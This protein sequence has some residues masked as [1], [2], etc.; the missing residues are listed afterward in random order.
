MR[1][2]FFTSESVAAGHPDKVADQIS[3]GILDAILD[4]DKQARV[5]VESLVTTGLVM[6]AG[7]VTT[8]CYV[9]VPAVARDVV[10]EVGYVDATWGFNYETCA[11]VSSIHGQSP[12]ISQGVSEGEGLHEEQGAGDQGLMFGY[13]CDETPEL[14]PLP[15]RLCHRMMERYAK[16]QGAKALPWARPDG[17][18]QVTVEYRGRKP[19]RVHT[20]VC[21]V[22]HDPDATHDQV[23]KD[24]IQKIIKKVI[25]AKLL[26]SSTIYH[27]NPTGRF[28]MGG[29]MADTGLTGRKIIVDTYG[30]RGRHGGGA[31]SGKDPSKVDRSASY[32]A[33]HCAKNIVAAGLAQE[34]EVQVSYAIGVADPLA[35]YV[36]TFGTG[37]V[38]EQRVEK[39]VKDL[40][41][42]RPKPIIQR[43]DLLR[44]IYKETARFGHFGRE[45][46]QFTWERTDM[47]EALRKAA[48][49]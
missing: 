8:D 38:P 29:P 25:P 20:V 41:D 11:V 26:D 34:C 47:V 2:Y 23:E 39:I 49:L 48:K 6:V 13:A 33:R 24:I 22:Q 44:P 46:P 42:F 17:K 12:D 5:A 9:D 21:S 28:V 16:L 3:D 15:I 1:K 36:D 43:L 27:V 30:G 37:K 14:M 18:C 31:F 4:R 45:L 40:F 7:E 10:R 35:I 19:V 32:A